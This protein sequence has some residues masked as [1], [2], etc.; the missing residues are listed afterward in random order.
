VKRRAV[1]A[2]RQTRREAGGTA[3]GAAAALFAEA[4]RHHQAG[5]LAEA[6]AGYGHVLGLAPGHADTLHQLGLLAYQ[7][8]DAP[9]AADLIEQAIALKDAVPAFHLHLGAALR[10]QGK[11]E[12]AVMSYRRALS[13]A[14]DYAEAH[15]N[16]GNVLLELGRLDEAVA[17]Y[18][19]AVTLRP[20]YAEAQNSLG[21]L[22][23][24]RGKPDEAEASLRRAA[25]KPGFADAHC[26]LGNLL[27]SQGRLEEAA[28]SYKRAVAIDPTH[29]V[30]YNNLGNALTSQGRLGQAI[31]AYERA[32]GVSPNY[33]FAY[34]NLGVALRLSGEL[35]KAAS[36]FHRALALN[37]HYAEAYHNLAGVLV[38]QRKLQEARDCYAQALAARSDYHEALAE[39]VFVSRCICNWSRPADENDLLAAL[40]SRKTRI[41]PFVVLNIASMPAD[42]LRCASRWINSL[43]APPNVQLRHATGDHATGGGGKI[44]LGYLS[45]DFH[46]HATAYLMAELFER[47][48]RSRFEVTGYSFGPDDGSSTRRRLVGAF[49]RFLDIRQSG[50]AEAARLIK[51]DGIDILVD[52]KGFTHGARTQ[53]LT[54]RPAPVQVNFLGYPGTM[55]SDCIDYAIVDPFVVPAEQAPFYAEK[56]AYLPHCYQPN[57]RSREIA[58]ATPARAACGLPELGFVFC[59]FNNSY[60]LT[61]RFFDVWTRLLAALPGS[62]L[63]LLEDNDLASGNLQ[64]E[65]AARGIAPERLVFAPRLPLAQHLA[66]HRL[67]DLFLDTLPYNAHTTASDALWAGLPVLTCA[68]DSFAGRVAGSLLHAVGLPELVTDTLQDYET[69]ALAL[70]RDPARLAALRQRLAANRAT[71]PLFDSAAYARAIEAAFIRMWELHQTGE[72]PRTFMVED[73]DACLPEVP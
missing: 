26:N 15:N 20:D 32:I 6:E 27:Q 16:L 17:S 64:R 21:P 71:A 49:D 41:S 47:H 5:R 22:L 70:A 9:R 57:D 59:C 10:A 14:P 69:L 53:I 62:V 37:P 61:P 52:L 2:G 46:A 66:R 13:L 67:A 31:E 29:A 12:E 45:A 55:G 68:G 4:V 28:E 65:A 50:H 1:R 44:R 43:S 8:G 60:K 72:A 42:Q 7:R 73:P 25:L 51:Q 33:I 54:Y 58:E 11:P 38:E 40:R 3:S 30:A 48:D 18:Q 23:G 24:N 63:W 36:V 34:G 39:L 56:L 35:D 19:R